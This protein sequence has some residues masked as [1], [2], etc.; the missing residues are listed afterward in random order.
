VLASVCAGI[1]LEIYQIFT[2]DRSPEVA[3]AV[4]DAIG[5]VLGALMLT[6]GARL[7]RAPRPA[8]REP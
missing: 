1:L 8:A 6:L 3:D 2:P 7:P 4:A 5:A